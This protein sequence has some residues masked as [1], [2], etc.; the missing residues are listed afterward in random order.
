M[1]TDKKPSYI[2]AKL[3]EFTDRF[4]AALEQE[5]KERI[6]E[7][8]E[9]EAKREKERKEYEAKRKQEHK[10]YEAKRE[11]E[12]KE[13]EAKREKERKEYEAKREKER[14][15]YRREV[16][17]ETGKLRDM[18][19]QLAEFVVESG[20]L[21]TL[22]RHRDLDVNDA[23]P[24]ISVRRQGKD[25][26]LEHG[27]LD[28]IVSGERDTIIVETK[29]TLTKGDVNYFLNKYLCDYTSWQASSPYIH[30]PSCEGRRIFGCMAYMKAEDGA[31]DVAVKEGLITVH[32]FGDSSD[33]AHP[34]TVLVDYHPDHY[35]RT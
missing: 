32:A 1:S 27:Q 22:N 23:L 34:D 6:A 15:E 12:H 5:R 28:I 21:E 8:K 9:H 19:G 29:T 2:D 25:G 17:V 3:A 26:K 4:E 35:K 7:R 31:E 30:L 24:N 14:K 33:I 16:A 13:Y 20:I 10:E 18:W 11:K